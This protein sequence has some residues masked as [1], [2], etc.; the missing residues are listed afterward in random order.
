MILE[1]D[2]LRTA[3]DRGWETL[4]KIQL[5]IAKKSRVSGDVTLYNKQQYQSVQLYANM[6]AMQ[7]IPFNHDIGQNKTIRIL[8]NNIKLM[9]KN[10]NRWD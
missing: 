3:M 8:Y 5:N 7:Q 9:T 2:D 10:F 6:T 4:A 1:I